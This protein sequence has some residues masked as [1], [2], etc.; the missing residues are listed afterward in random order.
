[1][2]GPMMPDLYMNLLHVNPCFETL[3]NKRLIEEKSAVKY[4][5]L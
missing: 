4:S 2:H 5:L 1:M 3:G